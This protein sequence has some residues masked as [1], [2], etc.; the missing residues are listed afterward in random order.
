M[1]RIKLLFALVI[2]FNFSTAQTWN[3]LIENPFNFGGAEAYG[4]RII[5]DTVYVSSVFIYVD[6]V[7]N[8]RAVISK[9]NI[10]TGELIEAVP[11]WNENYQNSMFNDLG[12]GYN[13]LYD[14]PDEKF[15]MSYS[16]FEDINDF[17]N[18]GE[19][20][21]LRINKNLEVESSVIIDGF[22][23]DQIHNVQGTRL[24]ND[25]NILCYGFRSSTLNY[26]DS[27]SANAWLVKMSPN[28]EQLWTRNYNHSY[29]VNALCPM[30]DGDIVFNCSQAGYNVNTKYLIKANPEGEEIWRMQYGGGFT[31][32]QA[33]PIEDENG[34]ILV[35]NNW[36]VTDGLSGNMNIWEDKKIQVQRIS[37][38][39]DSYSILDNR[40]FA[41]AH[42]DLY[43]NGIDAMN[44]GD[45]IVW[46]TIGTGAGAN[47]IVEGDFQYFDLPYNRG[48]ILKLDGNLDSLWMRT[49][50]I[51]D[52]DPLQFY[53]DYTIAD[54][55]EVETGGFVT[56]GWG[57]VNALDDL[58]QV[59]VMRL[60][61]FGCLEPG[62][63]NVN[64][65]EVVIGLEN[66]M[67]VYPNPVVDFCT[68]EFNISNPESHQM[69]F[70]DTELVVIDIQGK[71]VQR[72]SI[73]NFG[74][75]YKVT[76]DVQS[77]PAGAYQAHWVK[78][79]SWLDSVQILK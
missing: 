71:E 77:L 68:I 14:T 53:S 55:A 28:G 20:V 67:I 78:N 25:G 4:V 59:W 23:Y 79:N 35:A 74:N 6:S 48:F 50:F 22:E 49:Y 43:V 40:K 42:P 15:H 18:R 44:S 27:D 29:I 72:M 70:N 31:G 51:D 63:Q 76:L 73:P 13:Q 56:A 3:K 17:E 11:F 38:D 41:F 69:D 21:L 47:Y 8:N 19:T 57:V 36:N 30:S 9:H 16:P 1:L 52:E 34:N 32:G 54:V 10:N 60:D 46:G 75:S 33:F 37:D 66:T 7:S 24:D 12:S 61:E 5:D 64:V 62:C 65:S 39:G 58:N 45:F 26:Y 2:L